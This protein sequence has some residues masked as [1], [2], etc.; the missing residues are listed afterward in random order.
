MGDSFD[1]KNNNDSNNEYE[2]RRN[3]VVTN[4][5]IGIPVVEMVNK[6]DTRMSCTHAISI[7]IYI[8][9]NTAISHPVLER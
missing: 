2:T 6:S 9:N 1:K 7:N 4:D 3:L 5:R 8:R